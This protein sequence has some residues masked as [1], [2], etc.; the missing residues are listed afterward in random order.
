MNPDSDERYFVRQLR[1]IGLLSD[2]L[3]RAILDYY[4]AFEQRGMW[5][6][7]NVTLTGELEQYDDRLMNEWSRLREIVFEELDDRSPE[8]LM[9]K[10]GRK[11]LNLLSTTGNPNLR[12]RTGVTATFVTMGSYHMLANDEHPRVYWHPQ[13]EERIEEILYGRRP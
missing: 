1:A 9:K 6:R 3:R 11:L 10:T 2:R 7:E 5:V 13:F 8:E 4:R 12:V